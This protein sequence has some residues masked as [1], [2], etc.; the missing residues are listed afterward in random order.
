MALNTKNINIPYL[1]TN[2]KTVI[3]L[4]LKPIVV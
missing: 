4:E 2:P 3:F 1:C